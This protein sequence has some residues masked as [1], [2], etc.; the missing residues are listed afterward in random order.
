MPQLLSPAI[1]FIP[2]INLPQQLPVK[3]YGIISLLCMVVNNINP[4]GLIK[5]LMKPNLHLF[6][7]E[8]LTIFKRL[9]KNVTLTKKIGNMWGLQKHK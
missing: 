7:K 9:K 8:L 3:Y 2:D 4:I 5:A 6:M 1:N